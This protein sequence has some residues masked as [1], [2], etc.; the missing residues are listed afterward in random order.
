MTTRAYGK[1]NLGL[2][3]LRKRSDGY[4][5]IETVFH[6][7]DLFDELSFRLHERDIILNSTASQLPTDSSNLCIRAAHLLRDLT[8]IQEGVEIVLKKNIPMGAGLGGGSADAAATLLTLT[9]L[10]NLEIS[11]KELH[12]LAASLGSDVP[13]FLVGN[14]AYAISRGERLEPM[15]LRLPYWIVLV[16]PPVHVSTAWAYKMLGRDEHAVPLAGFKSILLEHAN[17]QELLSRTLINDFERVVFEIHPEIREIK[18]T[19]LSEGAEVALMS[20]SGS[21]VFGLTKSEAIAGRLVSRL[22]Q[23]GRVFLTKPHFLAPN[24]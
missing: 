13:F 17:D 19:M 1:I 9:R 22:D 6:L 18:E 7:I 11:P 16:T 23:A 24:S 20:G 14:T 3:I 10:W 8:G 21:S 2:R 4:H 5:D 15:T 12:T